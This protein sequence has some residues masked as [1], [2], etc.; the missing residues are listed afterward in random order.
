MS[1][2]TKL[3]PPSNAERA[4]HPLEYFKALRAK[5]QVV[6]DLGEKLVVDGKLVEEMLLDPARYSSK[7]HISFGRE[8]P[9][10]P[11][12]VDGPAHLKYR[13]LLMPLV[14]A[15]R[16]AEYEPLLVKHTNE[17]IDSFIDKGGCELRQDL[18]E[19][20]PCDAFLNLLGLP[21]AD[22]PFLLDFK[23]AVLRPFASPGNREEKVAR[24]VDFAA[25][26]EAYF[27]EIVKQRRRQPGTDFVSEMLASEI[28]GEKLTDQ[29]VIDI[30]FQLPLAG[31][32]TV[33]S[34]ILVSWVFLAKNEKY[35]TMIAQR[36]EVIK[37]AVEELL[38]LETPTH[39][40]K[41]QVTSDMEVA[42]CP[43]HA[44]ER[45]ILSIG[46]ANLDPNRVQRAE[47]VDFER[48]PNRH[49][50]F[51]AGPH[52]CLGNNFARMELRVVLAE[53]HKRI[54]DYRIADGAELVF[55]DDNMIRTI[56]AVPLQW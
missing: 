51:G 22:K 2:A 46:S 23:D 18:A 21:L 24:Q 43:F 47:E 27:A 7:G 6:E 35:R 1:T 56:D 38:R 5:G 41:R 44:G 8:R 53:W 25:Q 15:K 42:G 17:L 37:T 52:T 4:E 48:Q 9:I 50:A 14:S 19:P 30:C 28:D 20:V 26:G 32:D 11:Q 39:G 29:D 49:L 16:V 40:L 45:V 55:S 10:I 54:P 12:Q 13:R 33:T 31:L 36:P 3:P 34:T